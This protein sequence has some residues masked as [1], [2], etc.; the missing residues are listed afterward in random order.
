MGN[1]IR[2]RKPIPPVPPNPIRHLPTKVPGQLTVGGIDQADGDTK[3]SLLHGV[4]QVAVVGDHYCRVDAVLQQVDQ[5]V[6]RDIDV[7][8]LLLALATDTMNLASRTG[9]PVPSCTV[10]GQAGRVNT[11][12]P[13]P[14]RVASGA[15]FTRLT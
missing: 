14:L 6:R 13:A 15:I 1:Q 5:E 7:R 8:A 4:P 12:R 3:S 11:G 10:I 9:A 2:T